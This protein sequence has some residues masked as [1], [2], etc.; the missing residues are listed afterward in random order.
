MITLLSKIGAQMNP[1]HL[2]L[3]TMALLL[4]DILE[5]AESNPT[6]SSRTIE[7]LASQI[8]D[9]DMTLLHR[10]M[11]QG[12]DCDSQVSILQNTYFPLVRLLYNL[13]L[14]LS[15]QEEVRELCQR[16]AK[17]TRSTVAYPLC[18]QPRE[19]PRTWCI[20][21]LAFGISK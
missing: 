18:C 14:A 12:N 6:I 21:F 13:R 16:C 11:R 8:D 9:V 15:T 20:K 4:M 3:A 19:A 10:A 5:D 7:S 17:V 1:H 2:L